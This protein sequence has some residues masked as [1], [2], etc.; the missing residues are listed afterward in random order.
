MSTLRSAESDVESTATRSV[1]SAT[2][3]ETDAAMTSSDA[4]VDSVI[5]STRQSAAIK[6]WATI[7][8][9]A[10]VMQVWVY[11]RFIASG[12]EQVTRFRDTSAPSYV[13]AKIFEVS[14]VVFLIITVTAVGRVA[15]RQRRLTREAMFLIGFASVLWL[16]PLLNYFRPGFY[17]SSNFI[18]VE[19]WTQ[20]IPFS[21]APHSNLNPTPVLWIVGTYVGFFLPVILMVVKLMQRV[22]RRWPTASLPRLMAAGY[23][24]ALP[25]DLALELSALRTGTFAYP[26]GWRNFAI[27]GGETYQ[28]PLLEAIAAPMF[29]VSVAAMIYSSSQRRAARRDVVLDL[30]PIEY[31]A[32]HIASPRRATLARLLAVIGFS[33]V[34]FLVLPMGLPQL[35]IIDTDP[36]PTNYA[37]DLHNGWCGD[38]GEPY[39]PCPGPG[40][41]WQVRVGRDPHPSEIG[42]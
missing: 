12:P 5:V 9:F 36:F 24:V 13:W 27:W 31:G 19:S 35:G 25:M 11:G 2:D 37:P 6:V 30:M 39:G 15:W 26:S 10:V 32:E 3:A 42:G 17:F 8:A 20:Y 33:N 41:P 22:K 34:M 4:A 23:L 29:W 1:D 40:V 16:D 38:N 18:N 7:G 28:F 14:E 21:V